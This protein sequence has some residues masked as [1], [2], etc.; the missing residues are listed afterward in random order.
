MR[1]VTRIS[2]STPWGPPRI[3]LSAPTGAARISLSAPCNTRS[4]SASWGGEGQAEVGVTS[5]PTEVPWKGTGD[6]PA[7]SPVGSLAGS[8]QP[9]PNP[10]RPRGRSWNPELAA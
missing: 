6:L 7:Q 8:P 4:L 2:R 9:H 5:P 3:W 1:Q 10:L